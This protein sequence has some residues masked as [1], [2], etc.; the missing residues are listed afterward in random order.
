MELG[1][2]WVEEEVIFLIVVVIKPTIA[3]DKDFNNS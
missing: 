3:G 2:R 1:E